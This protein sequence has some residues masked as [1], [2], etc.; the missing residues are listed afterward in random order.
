MKIGASVQHSQCQGS[1]QVTPQFSKTYVTR[2]E[3]DAKIQ[4]V[5]FFIE[6]LQPPFLLF[7]LI[8]ALIMKSLT[9]S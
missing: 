9:N 8:Y 2:S 5:A 3:V 6:N 1:P 7:L 4:K